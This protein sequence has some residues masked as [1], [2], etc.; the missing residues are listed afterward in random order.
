[1]SYIQ[2]RIGAK[3]GVMP[4]D[5]QMHA[6]RIASNQGQEVVLIDQD[7]RITVS[8]LKEIST[9]EK[10]KAAGLS[11]LSV[12]SLQK[13]DLN[14]VPEENQIQELL[15]SFRVHLPGFYSVLIEERNQYMA[16]IIQNI[17]EK[18]PESEVLVILGAAHLPGIERILRENPEVS[19]VEKVRRE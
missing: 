9:L 5:E 8:R 16:Q 13:F 1:M 19:N 4:G 10:L 2:K 17:R 18:N 7:I 15:D 3:T 6:Y 12:F 14:T 11:V